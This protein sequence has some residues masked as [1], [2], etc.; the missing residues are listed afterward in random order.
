MGSAAAIQWLP[1]VATR[2]GA[3]SVTRLNGCLG[4]AWLLL[5]LWASRMLPARCLLNRQDLGQQV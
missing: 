5:W 1:G 2:Y 3:A 4:L